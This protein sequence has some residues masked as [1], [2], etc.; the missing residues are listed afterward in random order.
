MPKNDPCVDLAEGLGEE[1]SC[2]VKSCV[3]GEILENSNAM[4]LEGD[5]SG[6]VTEQGNEAL[7]FQ[8][9]SLNTVRRLNLFL[10]SLPRI[11]RMNGYFVFRYKP[12]DETL[13]ELVAKHEGLSL[14][15]AYGWHFVRYRA[16]PKVRILE[17]IYFSRPLSRL[18][19]WIY[20]HTKDRRRVISRAEMWGRMY[21]WG[22]EVVAERKIGMDHW[23]VTRRFREPERE[24]EPSFFPIAKLAKVGP[25]GK[26]I[27]QHKIRTMYPFSEY[28]Q[29]RVYQDHGL[30]NTGKFQ[31][32]YRLTDYG[33]VLRKYWL[34]ELPQLYDWIRGD[35]KL[36]GM[37]ATSHHYLGLYPKEVYD[38]YIKTKP[39]LIP[40]IFSSNTNGFEDIVRV[41]LE[42]LRAY[43]RDPIKTDIKYFFKTFRDI[44]LRGVRSK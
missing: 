15:A 42:Y 44:L 33:K 11:V 34:D 35:I 40:P 20:K 23:V 24:K 18:D 9:H 43:Q 12:L 13:D 16:L 14:V 31:N 27:F 26:T 19:T 5:C 36:V 32:D 41:E 3:L 4:V 6:E 37:R 30:T 1:L 28:I 21:F 29:E 25:D 22:F 17:K 10:Q 8:K 2:F 39:G 38:L 7:V